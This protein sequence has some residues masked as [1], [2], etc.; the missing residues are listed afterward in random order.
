MVTSSVTTERLLEELWQSERLRMLMETR[1]RPDADI[2][3]TASAFEIVVDLAG[4]GDDDFEVQL[5]EDALVVE[6][7]RRLLAPRESAVYHAASIRQGPFRMNLPLPGPIDADRVEAHYD[8]GLLRV[9]LPKDDGD[10]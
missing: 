2:Y 6:G 1:W 10:R 8:R 7:Q 9:T 4:V 3:E 5:F